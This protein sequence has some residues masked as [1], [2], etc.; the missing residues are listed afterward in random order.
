MKTNMLFLSVLFLFSASALAQAEVSAYEKE[1]VIPTWEIGPPE[2]HPN[3]YDAGED[4]YPYTLNDVLTDKKTE[5]TYKGVFLENEYIQIL[6]LPEIGGRLHGAVDKTNGYVW[7]YWQ[8]TIKPGLISMTGAW[9]SGGIEW[10]F[11]HGHRPSGFMPVDRRIVHNADGSATVWVG[12]TEPIFRMRWLVGMTVF[13]GR[14]YVRCDYKFI[15]PTN[16]RHSF[17]FWATSAVHANE[18]MQAQYPGDVA[19]GHGKHQFWNWPIHDGVDLTWWKNSPNASSYFA[20]NNPSDW[21]GVFDHKAQAGM[22][23]AADHRLMPGKKLW[24]WG[25]GPSGRIWEDILSEGGG[26]YFEPQAGAFSDNQPDY[27]WIE[28]NEVKTVHDYWFP[29]RDT[30]GV[31]NANED[32][33]VNTDIKDGKTFAGVYATGVFSQCKIVLINTK[34]GEILSETTADLAPDK[35][36]AIEKAIG[37]DSTVY[38]LHLAVYDSQG[39]LRIELQQAKPQ[40]VELPAG[41]PEPDDPQKMNQDELLQTGEWLDKFRRTKQAETYYRQALNNDPKDSRAN[42]EMGFLALKQGKWNEALDFLSAAS[43]RNDDDARLYF[44][45]GLAYAG[46]RDFAKAYDAFFRASYSYP[47]YSSAYFNLAKIDLLRGNDRAAIDKLEDAVCQNGKFADIPALQAAAYRRLGDR[48]QALAAAVKALALDPMHF[49]GGW[50]KTQ[51]LRDGDEAAAWK[52]EWQSIMRGAVQNYL[53]LAS[54]YAEAGLYNDADAILALYAKGKDEAVIYPMVNYFRGYCKELS[55]GSAEK[56]YAQ[57]RKGPAEYANPHRQ[58]EKAALEAVL[59]RHPDDARAHLYLGN[60]LYSRSQRE[61]G[62]A[63]WRQAAES[64]N[65]LALAW[66]NVAYGER[67]FKNDLRASQSAYRKTMELVPKDACVLLEYDQLCEAMNVPAAER[68]AILKQRQEVA[69]QRDDLLGRLIDLQLAAGGEGEL[70]EVYDILRRRHFHSWEGRYGIHYC[71]MEVNQK[72]GDSAFDKKNYSEALN[73][74]KAACLYPNNLEVAARTPDFRAHVY[75]NLAKTY[76]TVN[77][78]EKAKDYCQKILEEKYRKANLGTYYQALAQRAL[79]HADEAQGLMEQLEKRARQMLSSDR[80]REASEALGHYFLSLI[81]QEKN[82][83][84]AA[85]E[86]KKALDSNPRVWRAAV[87]EA[88]FDVSNAIQ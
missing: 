56:F 10:N 76:L 26:P 45:Q 50:E 15:N 46:Q 80:R 52:S 33:A 38:D 16:H 37:E 40:K 7:L 23:H 54:A 73:Y 27:H 63:H 9:I 53:E 17:Q 8:R 58:E 5:K 12:E 44:G 75:W 64:D 87:L 2:I 86:R 60:L 51:A 59:A 55:G 14:S 77:E 34:T 43:E 11:P 81:L 57:A 24:T 3:F 35:P 65:T 48:G 29:V 49:M 30:R 82:E 67:Y 88:Q 68:L 22:I 4:I 66:R 32:F 42:A 69:Q 36:F 85:A 41:K 31:H 72:L 19:A 18:W 78:T 20:F 70:A 62:F 61:E 1:I 83:A 84:D 6:I 74:Y 21:F 25:S 71:W 79:G 13:P 39:N 28:P 47:Y